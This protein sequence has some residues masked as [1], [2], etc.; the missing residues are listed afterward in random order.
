MKNLNILITRFP[1]E[2][3]LGGEELHTLHLAEGLI[4]RGHSVSLLTSCPVL[5]K[6]FE[7]KLP[8]VN[9][10]HIEACK[11]P[12]SAW[13]LISFT[14]FSPFCFLY[15]NFFLIKFWLKNRGQNNV[16]YSL[17]LNEKLLMSPVAALLGFNV[18]WVE[19]AR[20]GNW[21]TQN[22]WIVFYWLWS[23]FTKVITPSAGTAAPIKWVKNLNV[24][25]HG[26]KLGDSKSLKKKSTTEFNILCIARLSAD[27]GVD[28]LIKAFKKLIDHNPDV[29]I[30][31]S[32]AG[33]GPEEANL[34]ALTNQ[35]LPDNQSTNQV[36]FL[37]KIP[38]AEVIKEYEKANVLVLPSTEHDPFGLTI[39]EGMIMGCAVVC[40]SVCGASEFL[41][42]GVEAIVTPEKDENALYS[43]LNALLT[44]QAFLTEIAGNGH[45]CATKKFSHERMVEDYERVFGS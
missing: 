21:L 4:G 1:F 3:Q 32:I 13:S 8:D 9:I 40:T 10:K 25:C 30:S 44:N 31:L 12:V 26:V 15:L 22:P 43:A 6:L 36:Q 29:C 18:V 17:S 19:H 41:E 11:P 45:E 23:R 28:Y 24:I 5:E 34:K 37:G 14:L 20:I 35:L 42:S 2:S 27:K 7:E 33:N 39:V 16:L 38:H